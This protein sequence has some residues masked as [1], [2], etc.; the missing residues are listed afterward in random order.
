M[1]DYLEIG[2]RWVLF[3]WCAFVA[4][5]LWTYKGDKWW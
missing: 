3:G 5:R 1:V 2:F 4:L